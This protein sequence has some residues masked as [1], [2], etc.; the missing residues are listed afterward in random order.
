MQIN[1]S[2][3]AT[4]SDNGIVIMDDPQTIQMDENGS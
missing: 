2:F 1:G 3:L 4:V